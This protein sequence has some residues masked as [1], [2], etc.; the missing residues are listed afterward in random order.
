MANLSTLTDSNGA[1]K[2]SG[3]MAGNYTLIVDAGKEYELVREPFTLDRET[4]RGRGMSRTITMPVYLR[5]RATSSVPQPGVVD[6][7][8]AAPQPAQDAYNKGVEASRAGD[9]QQAVEHLKKAIE[10]H[11]EF[12]LALN[13]L[14]VQYLRLG[15]PGNAVE[16]LGSAVKMTPEA[17]M[18]RLN[19]GIALLENKEIAKAESELR[20]AVKA[21]EASPVAHLYLG[22]ALVKQKRLDEGAAELERAVAS[23][24]DD[25]AMAHYYL[26]GIY[27]GRREYKRAADSLETYLKLA[28]EAPYAERLRSTIRELRSKQQK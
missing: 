22:I 28:P 16:P 5:P 10:L 2:F 15:Q 9:L 12:P 11:P 18:P 3:L 20:L 24:R 8:H 6:A 14:G 21:N 1:F 4:T 26:G 7:R 27:W 13:E 23:G 25:M 19:F 17:F